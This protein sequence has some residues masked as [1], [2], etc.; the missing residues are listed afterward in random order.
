MAMKVVQML[1]TA[2]ESYKDEPDVEIVMA[3]TA[4]GKP[5]PQLTPLL[6]GRTEGWYNK[7]ERF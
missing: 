4:Y 6:K 3:P 1:P 2:K 5:E 7:R